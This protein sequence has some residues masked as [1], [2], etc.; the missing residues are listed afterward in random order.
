MIA[1]T[2]SL[3]VIVIIAV[4]FV[5]GGTIA[6]I[7]PWYMQENPMMI[8]DKKCCYQ[9]GQ[10]MR[11]TFK[12]RALIGFQGHVTR[13]L[14]WINPDSGATE[15]IWKSSLNTSIGRG[16]NTIILPY[17]IPTL[18]M[19]PTMQ[20]NTYKWQGSLSYEPFNMVK[21]I[22]FFETEEFKIEVE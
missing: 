8:V 6:G 13:E 3:N 22:F 16:E 11:V 20:G 9:P 5:V 15:E 1:F 4:F 2:K 21:K 18:A 19:Y 17:T 10:S 7:I 14:V 12:R